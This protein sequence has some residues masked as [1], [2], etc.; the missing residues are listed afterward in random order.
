MA[1]LG[2]QSYRVPASLSAYLMTL[3][4]EYVPWAVFKWHIT[5]IATILDYRASFKYLKVYN[6]NIETLFEF[7]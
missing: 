7:R 5:K 2:S 4:T 6:L 1:Y 3:E